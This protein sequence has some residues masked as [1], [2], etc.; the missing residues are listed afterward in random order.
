M[1]SDEPH[2]VEMNI[3]QFYHVVSEKLRLFLQD[4]FQLDSNQVRMPLTGFDEA[5]REALVNCLVHA[6]YAQK[7]PSIRIEAF[8]RFFTFLNPGQMLISYESYVVGGNSRPRNEQLMSFFRLLGLSER[9]GFG[10]AQIFKSA[11]ENLYRLPDVDTNHEQTK[12][13]IWYVDLADSY[14][15]M[16]TEEKTILRLLVKSKQPLS[17]KQIQAETGYNEYKVRKAIGSLQNAGHVR[18]LGQARSTRYSA[19]ADFPSVMAELQSV[20]DSLRGSV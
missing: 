18:V 4:S 11:Y 9:Q 14:P 20:F 15:D 5:L 12:V 10:G 2:P 7:H 19:L 8:D 13:K 6:D 3:F 16:S 17:S 1:A